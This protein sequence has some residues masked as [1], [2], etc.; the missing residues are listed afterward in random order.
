MNFSRLVHR[1]AG[2][3]PK[4][5]RLVT[6]W[7]ATVVLYLLCLSVS[8][9]EVLTGAASLPAAA[10]MTA[11]AVSGH[12]AFYF[13]IRQ[14]RAL[15]LS[16]AQLSVFQGRFAILITCIGYTI[17]GP[18]RGVTLVVLLVIIVFCAFTLE[19][20]KTH[21]LAVFAVLLLGAA[22]I[23]MGIADPA[24]FDIKTELIHFILI[25]TMVA[26]VGFLTGLMSDL[27][28]ALH[29]QKSEL[30]AALARIQ[31]LATH[32]ELTQLPNRRYMTSQLGNMQRRQG[33]RPACLALV[34][35]DW[36]KRINDGHGHAAGDE[37]LR[38]FAQAGRAV[39]RAGDVLARWGGEEFLL[40]LPD[41][42]LDQARG[43]VER[44]RTRVEQEQFLPAQ[45]ALRIGIG[46]TGRARPP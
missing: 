25:G 5:V 45:P 15:Q 13:L 39:L 32:D 28:A 41:T 38:G 40:L 44:L 12:V 23:S 8:W 33:R 36:F 26:V 18:L 42:D 19:A 14:S 34:D 17:V 27:R 31:D 20:R 4:M 10:A 43:V 30:A 6:Y 22:M 24:G 1:F 9:V 29:A 21:S 11:L 3:D 7:A 35:I 16:P 46:R 37:V 2:E